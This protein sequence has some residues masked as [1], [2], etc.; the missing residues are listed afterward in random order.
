MKNIPQIRFPE[1]SGEWV[2]K[3]LGEIGEIIGGGTPNTKKKEY[4][5]GKIIWLTPTEIKQKYISHSERTI[6]QKGLK[7]SSAKLLPKGTILITTRATIGDIGI[8]Q[9]ECATNQGFQSLIVNKTNF[10]EFT[11]YL[12]SRKN[13]KNE[14]IKKANGTTFLEINKNQLSKIKIHIPPTLAEQQKIANFLSSI[15]EKID[16]ISKKIENLKEY[17]KG[18]MRKMLNVKNGTP[19]LRFPEFSGEWIEKKFG[20]VL[21]YEQPTKYLITADYVNKG[22]PVLTAGKTFIL[23]YTNE[24]DNIYTN[25]PV[26][27]F[28]DFTTDSKFVNFPFKLKS[29]AIKILKTKKGFDAKFI[30]EAMQLIKFKVGGHQRHWIKIFS[31]LKIHI[32]KNL[33]EQQK[34]A[35]FLSLIDEKIELN[36]QVLDKLKEYK[37]GLLQKMFV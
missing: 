28:D 12:L 33:E 13:I 34:I 5:N 20:E 29:S 35:E 32:P 31:N 8:A 11:Y 17:K 25:L 1:F 9:V 6:T 2:E 15:D 26:I 21:A 14:M 37:R 16:I 19:E 18:I 23:G 36:E 27:I 24:T 30:Y 10:N 4:W 7:N 3:R 22:T